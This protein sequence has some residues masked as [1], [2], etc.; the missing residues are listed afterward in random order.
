MHTS[1]INECTV[2]D[3]CAT[4][5]ACMNTPGSFTCTCNQGYTGGG[6]RCRGKW[7]AS[8]EINAIKPILQILNIIYLMGR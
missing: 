7:C 4:N 6:V 2:T 8:D 5:A 1:D 3:N